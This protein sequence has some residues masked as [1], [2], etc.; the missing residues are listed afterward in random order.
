M[1]G[2]EVRGK[3]GKG[4]IADIFNSAVGNVDYEK[5]YGDGTTEVIVL[6]GSRYFLRSNDTIGFCLFSYYNGSSTKIDF[7][8]IGGGS[9][10]LNIRMGAGNKVENSMLEAFKG[11]ADSSGMTLTSSDGEVPS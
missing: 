4:Q 1:K 3:L 9:G 5:V 10:L 8:R 6:T 7:G 11:V 2:I